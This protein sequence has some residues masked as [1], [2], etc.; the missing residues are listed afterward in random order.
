MILSPSHTATKL[1]SIENEEAN[2]ISSFG[3]T[4]KILIPISQSTV[5]KMKHKSLVCIHLNPL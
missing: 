3:F 4:L 1:M 5:D 2:D